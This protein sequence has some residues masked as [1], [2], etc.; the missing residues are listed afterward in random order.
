[1]S[2]DLLKMMRL[3]PNYKKS[4]YR[5]SQIMGQ[6]FIFILAALIIGVI[7]LIGYSAISSTIN[8]SCEVEQLTFKTKI[9]SLIERSSSF[10]SLSKQSVIA[11][12]EYEKVCFIDATR[13]G[14]DLVNCSNTIIKKSASTSDMKNIF[15]STSKKTVPLGYSGLLRVDDPAGC[16][17]I[18]RR[19]KNFYLVLEGVGSDVSGAG[20]K[21]SQG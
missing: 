11:P 2:A 4:Y 21:V 7:I 8:K 12:C 6:I 5:K 1:M 19:N 20:T 9:E 13:I 10:G 18:S 3:K 16:T 15:V 14:T 17:C